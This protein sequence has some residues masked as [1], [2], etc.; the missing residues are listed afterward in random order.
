MKPQMRDMRTT[1]KDWPKVYERI[2]FMRGMSK[3][4]KIL[5][6]RGLAATPTERLE[7][8]DNF[9]RLNGIHGWKDRRRFCQL[10][11]KLNDTSRPGL[12]KLRLTN[13]ELAARHGFEP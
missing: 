7:M 11:R 3:D 8:H 1:V 10:R 13:E 12:W 9:L 4:E 5:F 6:A 2:K